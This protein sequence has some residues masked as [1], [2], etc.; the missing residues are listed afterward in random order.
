MGGSNEI[1]KNSFEDFY[2]NTYPV[3]EHYMKIQK[4]RAVILIYKISGDGTMEEV[5]SLASKAFEPKLLYHENIVFV[6][7]GPGSGMQF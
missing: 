6:L 3:I 5:F 4:C 2:T 7:G 1:I